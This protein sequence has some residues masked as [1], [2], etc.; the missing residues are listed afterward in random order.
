[1]NTIGT[2]GQ[3]TQYKSTYDPSL[4][5]P[6]KR[7]IKR[8]EIGIPKSKLPFKGV[9][10]W[11]AYEVSWL[12]LTGMPQVAVMVLEVPADSTFIVESK[13][14]KLYLNSFNQT[15]FKTKTEVL[16]KIKNDLSK[17][18]NTKVKVRL[19]GP[20]Q[21]IYSPFNINK[22]KCIDTNSLKDLSYSYDPNLIQIKDTKKVKR[23]LVTHLLKSNCLVTNQPDWGSLFIRYE[24]SEV[25]EKSL[26]RYIISF[27]QHNEFH[28]QC[29][30]RIFFDL[31]NTGLVH[32]LTVYARY[33]RRGGIDINPF[34]SNYEKCYGNFHSYRQ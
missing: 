4:I 27:R 7:A 16:N 15:R 22:F 19:C 24:G 3:K 10:I 20:G 23:S 9:D 30:E 13:S 34:R 25:D 21:N 32:K 8:D 29:V 33:T 11:N 1:M 28:E 14:L 12:S 31:M 26:L 18:L 2:L 17:K 5:F 6:I